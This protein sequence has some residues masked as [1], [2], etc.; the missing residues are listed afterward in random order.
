MMNDSSTGRETDPLGAEGDARTSWS[1]MRTG[2]GP[3]LIA[4]V[5]LLTVVF[6][7]SASPEFGVGYAA[8]KLV[9]SLAFGLPVFLLL[10]YAT[11]PGRRFAAVESLNL[12]CVVVAAMWVLQLAL[13]LVLPSAKS[14][15]VATEENPYAK[16][17]QRPTPELKQAD[18]DADADAARYRN[19]D[20]STKWELFTPVAPASAATAAPPQ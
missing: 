10:K 13:P 18:R 4:S 17:V 12:L 19:P 2:F 14:E 20:G 1:L 11:G 3:L 15:K 5:G 6:A 16:F 7:G 8:G 9:T